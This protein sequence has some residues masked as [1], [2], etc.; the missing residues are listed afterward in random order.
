MSFI[1]LTEDEF[2]EHQRS[3]EYPRELVE[4]CLA[5]VKAMTMAVAT[6]DGIFSDAI[7]DWRPGN[8]LSLE[9]I[10]VPV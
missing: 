8:P 9:H 5:E 1:Q 2:E 4:K 6:R 3:M 7:Y 10:T